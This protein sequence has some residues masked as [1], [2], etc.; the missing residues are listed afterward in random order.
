MSSSYARLAVFVVACCGLTGAAFAQEQNRFAIGVGVTARNPTDSN[1]HGNG[2]IGLK[3]RFGRDQTGWGWHYGLNWYV[4]DIDRPIG[5]RVTNFGE[6]K[7]RPFLGGY[8][9]TRRLNPRVSV[10]GSVIGGFAFTSF[11][12]S[13]EADRALRAD[14][15]APVHTHIS[16]VPVVRPE[17]AMW[18]DLNRKFGLA[19]SGGYIIARPRITLS[20]AGSGESTRFRADTFAISAGLVYSIF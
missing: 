18:Y 3:W 15:A 11:E 10:T 20:N 14:Q 9:Y 13:P 17:I 4:T 5:G 12:L 8:G 16:A 2:G 6:V 19:V 1:A 7:I